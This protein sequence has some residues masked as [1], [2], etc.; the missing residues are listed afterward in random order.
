MTP[1]RQRTSKGRRRRQVFT[2]LLLAILALIVTQQL[3]SWGLLLFVMVDRPDPLRHAG[4]VALKQQQRAPKTSSSARSMSHH[5]EIDFSQ[6]TLP[7]IFGHNFLS[8]HRNQTQLP[9]TFRILESSSQKLLLDDRQQNTPTN[10]C[11]P[12]SSSVSSLLT[13]STSSS[14][15]QCLPALYIVGFEKCGTTALNIWLSYHPHL[16]S[17]WMESRYFEEQF[18][19]TQ[20]LYDQWTQDWLMDYVRQQPKTALTDNLQWT[21]EKSPAYVLN[22]EWVPKLIYHHVNPHARFVCMTRNPTDRAYSMFLM[23]T[24]H[25]PTIWS[26][27]RQQPVSYLV[28]QVA[29]G[30]VRFASDGFYTPGYGNI[31]T[32][33]QLPPR[34][35]GTVVVP[36]PA[37]GTW[38]YLSYPPDPHDFDTFVTYMMDNHKAIYIEKPYTRDRRILLGGLYA[39]YLRKWLNHQLFPP[40]SLIVLPFEDFFL[41][42]RTLQSMDKLQSLLGLPHFDYRQLATQPNPKSGR[43]EIPS[44]WGTKLNSWLNSYTGKAVPMLSQT[45][46]VL[47]DFYCHSN[48]QL[49]TML[50]N[51]SGLLRGYSCVD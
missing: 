37:C 14:I 7:T 39:T 34:P 15:V 42:N 48:R 13:L 31:S 5:G 3:I 19:S 33:L 30:A 27:I 16:K 12:V 21:V 44:S 46:R 24:Q 38:Q 9:Q 40:S 6:V 10:L 23:Y 20:Q 35:G 29:T 47:D 51:Q 43:H 41:G 28:K 50:G 45:R 17:Q 22:H 1:T 2:I 49:W 36:C 26:A 32:K 18:P 25:Y 4:L 8:H 11:F